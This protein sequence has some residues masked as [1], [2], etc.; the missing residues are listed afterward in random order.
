MALIDSK[1]HLHCTGGRRGLGVEIDMNSLFPEDVLQRMQHSGV[2]AVLILDSLEL[3][4]PVAKALMDGGVDAMELT[5]RTPIALECLQAVR[6]AVPEML[7][8]V[9]TVVRPDQVDQIIDAGAAFGVSPG[10]NPRVVHR[11][12]AKQLPFA[13]GV[14]TP[15][16][17]ELAVELGCRELKFFPAEPSGGLKML[18]SIRAPFAHLGVSFIPLGGINQDNLTEYLQNP[19]VQAVGG[20]WLASPEHLKTHNWSAITEQAANARRAVDSLN[21]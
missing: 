5:L 20:S 9:G 8:G 1:K 12:I 4:V 10:L 18:N 14:M 19:G 21:R 16:D 11:A 17:V 2:I 6:R 15:T 13:P 7:A 3:A